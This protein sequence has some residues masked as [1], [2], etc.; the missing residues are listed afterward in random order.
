MVLEVSNAFE[1]RYKQIDATLNS[2]PQR[3]IQR[4]RRKHQANNADGKN[5]AYSSTISLNHSSSCEMAAYSSLYAVCM[6]RASSKQAAGNGLG[7]SVTGAVFANTP[8]GSTSSATKAGDGRTVRPCAIDQ[9]FNSERR[10]R[11]C[12][13]VICGG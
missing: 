7:N 10:Y 13:G 8:E 9:S 3:V 12:S 11:D 5:G 1:A 6:F 4:P 2:F